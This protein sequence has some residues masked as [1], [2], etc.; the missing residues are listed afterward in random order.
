MSWKD[1]V[2]QPDYDRKAISESLLAVWEGY[3]FLLLRYFTKRSGKNNDATAFILAFKENWPKAV[4]LASKMMIE[5]LTPYAGRLRDKLKC[6]YIVAAPPHSQGVAGEQ[7]ES[8]CEAVAE[9]FTLKHLPGALERTKTVQKAAY[10]G[11]G[12]RATRQEHEESIRW[13]G[14]ALDLR[15]EG[16]ILF[17]DVLTRGDTSEACGAVIRRATKCA[18]ITGI[19][20]GKTQ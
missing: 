10:A 8:L 1:M 3:N 17:D 13:V 5:G 15:K 14:P 11:P 20:L 4:K 18:L 9:H 16:I 2:V 12:G 6:R 7:S 19:F